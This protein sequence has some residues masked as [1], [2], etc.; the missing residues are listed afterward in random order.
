MDEI[1]ALYKPAELE[2]VAGFLR[3]TAGAG[4]AAAAQLGAEKSGSP[5]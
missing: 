5:A 1:C 4:A 2:L 3:R